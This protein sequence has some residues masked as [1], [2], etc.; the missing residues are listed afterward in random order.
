MALKQSSCNWFYGQ[1]IFGRFDGVP[2]VVSLEEARL[3]LEEELV[4]TDLVSS[5][6][7]N[8]GF[9]F[10]RVFRMFPLLLSLWLL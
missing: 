9:A 10:W 8:E 1:L 2:D 5:L 3:L 7:F 4:V 6:A